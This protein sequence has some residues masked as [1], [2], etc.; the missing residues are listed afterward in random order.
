MK[1]IYNVFTLLVVALV[2]LSLTACSEDDYDTNPYNKSG[3][4]LLAFGPSPTTRAQE[5]RITG[6]N[7]NS[8]DKVVFPGGTL[9]RAGKIIN[10]TGAEVEKAAFNSVD[11]ENIY[12]NIPDESVP[13]KIRLIAGGDTI[14]SEGTLT[15]KEP[16]TVTSVSPVTGLNAG[17][18]ISIKGDYVYNIAEVIFP[19]GVSGAPVMA[20]DFTYVSRREIRV[21]V[22]LA[23]ESGT[24][25]FNDG[26]DWTEDFKTPLEVITASV[27]SITENT[28]FGQQIQI[29][30][31]NLHTVESVI[32]PGGVTA[33]FTVSDD[34]TTITATVPAETKSGSVSLLLYSSDA[35]TTKEI[36]VPMIAITG[37]SKE[38]DVK[39]GDVIVMTGENFDRIETVTLPGYGILADDEYTISG[40]TLTFTV[41]EGMSDGNLEL[42]QNSFITVTQKFMMYS[43]AP[44]TVIWAGNFEIGSWNAG[45]QELAWGGYDWS[46]A[47]P[48]QVLTIY[49]KPNWVE[50]WSQIRV[51]NGSWAA[52]PGT[53]DVNPL[54]E[55]DTKFTVTLTQAMIDE[56]VANGGLVICGAW[57]TITKITLSVLEDV[58]WSGNFALGSWAAGLGDLSWG[59]Y[60]WS[61]VSAGTTLK[62]YYEVDPSVG[63]INIRFGNGS[64]QALPS[65]LSWG[66]DGNASPDPSE[67]SIK[68]VLTEADMDQLINSGGLVICGAGIICKKIVLQ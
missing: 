62:L 3:V 61:K 63:Y 32:F 21:I 39:V 41:P 7:M 47:K 31:V 30:G 29:V 6:T 16:I 51:S 50:G 45:L 5:I 23:A 1:K 22:P 52:L 36:S 66:N 59:G 44:E 42:Y 38:K 17:D 2:G 55:D 33:D 27:S 25:S 43:E 56:M 11:N 58:I 65:T 26:A 37:V 13:G 48:G 4:N 46:T 28:D 14:V 68:T 12:V 35:I 54:A 9:E 60:D 57:F 49:L 53:L 34:H 64:W 18:E 19:S 15:F 67:T 10:I 40:N 8:V 20:E 24:L